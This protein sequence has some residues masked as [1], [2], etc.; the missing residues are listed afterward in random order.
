MTLNILLLL[1]L[2]RQPVRRLPQGGPPHFLRR[3]SLRTRATPIA[4]SASYRCACSDNCRTE[5][6]P[7]RCSLVECSDDNCSSLQC[8]NRSFTNPPTRHLETFFTANDRGCGLRTKTALL[9]NTF[10]VEY[11]GHR[12]QRGNQVRSDYLMDLGGGWVL[13]ASK[14]ETPARYI[15]HSCE[16]NCIARIWMGA[17]G[18]SHI[19]ISTITE[20]APGQELTISYNGGSRV[21]QSHTLGN[22]KCLCGSKSCI[23]WL[24][25]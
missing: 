23:G 19:G 20:L 16:P 17:D 18:K 22:N 4:L 14:V 3:R 9:A 25:A 1:L 10:V 8:E 2:S 15:N 13:D 7:N 24:W 5:S 21:G 11:T 6:C 12:Y